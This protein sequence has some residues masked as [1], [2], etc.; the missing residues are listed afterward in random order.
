MW[1]GCS[2]DP[3]SEGTLVAPPLFEQD[4]QCWS[5]SD[6][7]KLGV[8]SQYSQ[9]VSTDQGLYAVGRPGWNC[10]AVDPLYCFQADDAAGAGWSTGWPL[11]IGA[12]K[13]SVIFCDAIWRDERLEVL[14]SQK[15][16]DG[17]ED[18]CYRL[19]YCNYND[20][21]RDQWSPVQVIDGPFQAV[22]PTPMSILALENGVIVA[23]AVKPGTD[24]DDRQLRIA[25]LLQP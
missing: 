9:L 8:T 23:Y 6:P 17:A 18:V 13:P 24:V 21:G 10:T 15:V 22:E 16:P 11:G 5:W 4:S 20:F 2:V 1:E 14:F 12:D 3:A 25:S 19:C 7:V